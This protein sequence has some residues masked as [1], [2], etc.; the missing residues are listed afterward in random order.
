MIEVSHVSKVYRRGD[1]TPVTALNDVSF[2]IVAGEFV[3]IR[4]PSGSGK[5][6]ILNI[7]GCLDT[8]T[9][10]TYRLEGEDVSGYSDRQ[11]SRIR[12]RK[13]GFVFQ[14]FNLIPRTTALENVEIP[15]IYGNGRVDRTKATVVL[16][17]VGLADR[18]RHYG[19]E[20]SGG[21]QQRVAIARALINDPHLILAD[22]PTGNL[23]SVA[24]ME[25]MRLLQDLNTE[26]RTIVLVTHDDAVASY[27]AREIVLRDGGIGSDRST[28]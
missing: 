13:I 21:E 25:I 9:S 10:G 20:L 18:T 16:Q 27:A 15:M 23:D 28:A 11:L 26:G 14:S 7:L 17:R 19:T 6:S 1:G 4:G 3:T 22:E 8:P 12:C 24:G 2:A 5:S